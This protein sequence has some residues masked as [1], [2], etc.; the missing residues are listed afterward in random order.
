LAASEQ[1]RAQALLDLMR[2]APQNV[3]VGLDLVKIGNRLAAEHR[4]Q[5][6]T[7]LSYML[8]ADTLVIWVIPTT[9]PIKIVR[10]GLASPSLAKEA[11]RA[12]A[13]IRAGALRQNARNLFA[14]RISLT[15]AELGVDDYAAYR[16]L[17]A[18]SSQR[19]LPNLERNIT[20]A[21]NAADKSQKPNSKYELRQLAKLLLP[22]EVLSLLPAG[23]ELVIVPHGQ[24]NL[25][26]FAA[27]PM[28]EKNELLGMRYAL[29]YA[30]S[31]TILTEVGGAASPS[32]KPSVNWREALIVGN[33]QMPT[34]KTVDGRP[35]TLQSLSGAEQEGRWVA[36]KLQAQF[37]NWAAASENQIRKR[38]SRAPL[39]HFATHGYAY[40]SEAHTRD[41][42]I[43]LAPG[44]GHDGLLKVGE[45][46]DQLPKL[47]AEL[48]V[49]S[50]CQTGLGNIKEA[51]G[52]IGL[53]R[54][55]LAKGA[56]SVLVSLWSVSDDATEKLMKAFYTHWLNDP[57][58]PRKAEALRRAQQEVH[59]ISGFEPP[60]YWAAF[61]LVGA[62]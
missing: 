44:E 20:P 53:Q 2:D 36:E 26:P 52:T 16:T 40:A 50:A 60:R 32:A 29:R 14:E 13:D 27:L 48:V 5:Q 9:G 3:R 37:L 59:S 33:P 23:G 47:Y 11:E 55:F 18:A 15:R 4:Q 31:L 6:A 49:L 45:I 58:Q 12:E 57:D 41:S 22:A 10:Q 56:R 38:A 28:N 24:L 42:F 25:L 51:E 17:F 8:A 7:V 39:M 35:I 46:L 1:G 34:I 62:R 21:K 43:A 54:A 30:P 61:Q 19:V